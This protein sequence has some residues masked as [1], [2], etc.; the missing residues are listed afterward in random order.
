[1]PPTAVAVIR[2]HPAASAANIAL[3]VGWRRSGHQADGFGL[4]K[5]RNTGRPGHMI[6]KLHKLS[7][8]SDPSR[9]RIHPID[10]ELVRIFRV[11]TDIDDLVRSAVPLTI[12]RHLHRS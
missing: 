8:R 5:R 4:K 12:L 3:G 1:M 6:Q 2:D 9:S 11:L 7:R 10:V